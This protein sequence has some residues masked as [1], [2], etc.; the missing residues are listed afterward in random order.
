MREV[1]GRIRAIVPP[2][3]LQAHPFPQ[4]PSDPVPGSL[5]WKGQLGHPPWTAALSG[6]P[7]EKQR[8]LGESTQGESG[9]AGCEFHFVPLGRLN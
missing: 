8:G 6:S 1:V 3:H 2:F 7:N 9:R 5:T 4:S